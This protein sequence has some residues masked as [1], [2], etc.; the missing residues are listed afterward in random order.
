M[1]LAM[2][3]CGYVANMYRLT[4][5]LHPELEL[6]GVCDAEASR[7]EV[8]GEL[9]GARVYADH[10]EA[11]ADPSVDLVLNLTNP[12]NHVPVTR[13]ASRRASMCS[14]RSRW[15]STRKRRRRWWRWRRREA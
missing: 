12:A 5:P 2:I 11:C 9:T 15:R 6:V 4:L 13:A 1:K 10:A 3:G 7:A 8:M 14:P